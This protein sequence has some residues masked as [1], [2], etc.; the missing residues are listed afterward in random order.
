MDDSFALGDPAKHPARLGNAHGPKP[1]RVGPSTAGRAIAIVAIVAAL[2]GGAF[3]VLKITAA[4][5]ERAADAAQTAIGQIAVAQDLAAQEAARRSTFAAMALYAQEGM[6][7]TAEALATF[8]PT[9]T[10]TTGTSTGPTVASVAATP[11]AFAVA[12]ASLSGGCLWSRV[13]AEGAVTFGAGKP[14]TGQAAMAAS[15]PSW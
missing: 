2:G 15:E 10:F 8:D 9:L 14:C 3:A 5:G 11:D 13:G 6:Y 4:G 12:V 7:P 1:E